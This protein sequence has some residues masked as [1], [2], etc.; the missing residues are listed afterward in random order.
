M[1]LFPL[2]KQSQLQG[3]KQHWN[4]SLHQGGSGLVAFKSLPQFFIKSMIKQQKVFQ[5]KKKGIWILLK[6]YMSNFCFSTKQGVGGGRRKH[7]LTL[8]CSLCRFKIH[9]SPHKIT[10]LFQECCYI[11]LAAL[12]AEIAGILTLWSGF[13]R[14]QQFGYI[15]KLL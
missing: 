14:S 11:F 1:F 3:N 12:L 8:V 10:K 4:T 7:L 9:F 5:L 6:F 15:I 13:G 2:N